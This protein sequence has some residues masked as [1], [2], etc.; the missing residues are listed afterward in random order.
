MDSWILLIPALCQNDASWSKVRRGPAAGGGAVHDLP[1]ATR[2]KTV[3]HAA[4]GPPAV[5]KSKHGSDQL[6]EFRRPRP[7]VILLVQAGQHSLM[8]RLA[9]YTHLGVLA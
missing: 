7:S 2:A 9:F 3:N 8:V 1:S 4:G 5:V 6:R